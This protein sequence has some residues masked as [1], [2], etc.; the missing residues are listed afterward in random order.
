MESGEA[1]T[2]IIRLTKQYIM[3]PIW[4]TLIAG[5]VLILVAITF[6]HR[7]HKARMVA[8]RRRARLQFED[9]RKQLEAHFLQ[10][11]AATGKPRGLRLMACE[12]Q[13]PSLFATDPVQ[14]DFYALVATTIR[15][16]AIEGGGME[17]V[18]AV[19][20]LRGATAVFV[21][22]SENWTT[23]GRIVF[24]LGPAETC[25]RFQ[26]IEWVESDTSA[27]NHY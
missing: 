16:E 15:F 27:S 4:I 14:D 13:G 6:W 26:L 1:A 2:V 17:E 22:R 25:S 7:G 9:R 19:G 23:K 11:A 21:L 24:N 8:G 3:Q 12:F 5:G 18:E 20:N 10:T